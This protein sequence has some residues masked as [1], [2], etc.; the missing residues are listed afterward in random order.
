MGVVK[1][2]GYADTFEVECT[3]CEESMEKRETSG[4]FGTEYVVG[5][6]VC[7]A[8]GTVVDDGGIYKMV[9]GDRSLEIRVA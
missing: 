3:E 9:N 6:D 4:A 1:F 5:C 7:G 8:T 2:H